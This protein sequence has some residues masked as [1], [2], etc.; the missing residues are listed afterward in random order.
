MRKIKIITVL[1]ILLMNSACWDSIEIE[2]RGFVIG[3][4]IDLAEKEDEEGNKMLKLTQ[5]FVV[6]ST[7]SGSGSSGGE[8]T[9]EAY[10]NI[11]SEGNTIFEMVR[12]VAAR[13]SRSPFYEHIKLIV[14]SEEVAKSDKFPDVM[15]YFLRYPEMRR[16]IQVM[17]TPDKAKDILELK[18]GSEKLPAMHIQS[19]SRNN[20]KNSRMVP[21]TRIGDL[22]ED[23]LGTTSF[24]IQ[25]ISKLS[26]EE[27]KITGHAVMNGKTDH[28]VGFIREEAT[29]GV[30]FITGEIEGGL[31]E[32]KVD[33]DVIVFQINEV[34][35]E[36]EPI[37]T[38][39]DNITFKIDITTMGVI[40]ESFTPINL[41]EQK[42]IKKI[43]KA[44]EERI[45]YFV[46]LAIEQV[47]KDL[48][49]DVLGFGKS[50][51]F[52]EPKLW[53]DLK[54]NWDFGENYFSKSEIDLN[55]DVTVSRNGAII[56][57]S[58]E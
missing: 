34:K 46:E 10:Q 48:K 2:Q 11:E 37:I 20:Y 54:D 19:I 31:L 33:G 44:V 53:K 14:I 13:T 35:T 55:I 25:M 21:P 7:M 22:H 50:I 30:N 47:Q 39:K 8:A 12:T 3:V 36:V 17:I 6:P 38:G 26:N 16:G 56:K 24:M 58:L 23:L 15:D 40:P 32:A 43:E 29:E 41:L 49:T 18:P 1:L 51:M 27:V 5:Q 4:G 52:K 28:L 9:E 42:E 45:R 57:S